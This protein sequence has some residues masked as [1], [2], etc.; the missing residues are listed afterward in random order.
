MNKME[1]VRLHKL[2]VASIDQDLNNSVSR[3]TDKLYKRVRA[4]NTL[5]KMTQGD[6]DASNAEV[7]K[8]ITSVMEALAKKQKALEDIAQALGV[9]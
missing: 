7:I 4:A 1:S 8:A 9:A 3:L 6:T 2:Q 5:R